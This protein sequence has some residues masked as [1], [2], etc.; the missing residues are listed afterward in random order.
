MSDY[1][2]AEKAGRE[3]FKTFAQQKQLT[4][5]HFTDHYSPYDVLFMSGGSEWLGEIKIR[6]CSQDKYETYIL[7]KSKVDNIKN[8]F[9][10]KKIMYINFFADNTTLTWD[11]TNIN[12][13]LHNKILPATTSTTTKKIKKYYYLLS[14][15]KQ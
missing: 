2:Q 9:P 3:L 8:N 10:S 13:P 4:I 11:I 14:R 15:F 7:E 12:L 1:Q 6:H 5:I